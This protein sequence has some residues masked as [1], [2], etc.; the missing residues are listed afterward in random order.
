MASQ[1]D[2]VSCEN[3]KYPMTQ[4]LCAGDSETFDWLVVWN[5]FS[6]ILGI[7]IPS[8]HQPVEVE[9]SNWVAKVL[10]AQGQ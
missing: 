6:H 7:I 1:R 4:E 2:D 5:I 9:N 8:N 10:A 3:E